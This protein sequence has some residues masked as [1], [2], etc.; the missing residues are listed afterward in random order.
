MCVS[1]VLVYRA[2]SLKDV[3][4]PAIAQNCLGLIRNVGGNGLGS[5]S[6]G[7][8]IST[9]ES[10][11]LPRADKNLGKLAAN[12]PVIWLMLFADSRFS[13]QRLVKTNEPTLCGKRREACNDSVNVQAV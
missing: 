3:A 9:D 13:K 1:L 5:S 7:T 11:V 6:N 4:E 10:K 12:S 8:R 2:L